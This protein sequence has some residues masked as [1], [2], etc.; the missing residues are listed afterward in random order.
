MNQEPQWQPLGEIDWDNPN[1][2][3][4]NIDTR[5]CNSYDIIEPN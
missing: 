5:G 4:F 1:G 2:N 3:W